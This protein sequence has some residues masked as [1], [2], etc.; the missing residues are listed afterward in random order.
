MCG[1]RSIP[2]SHHRNATQQILHLCFKVRELEFWRDRVPTGT[3]LFGG[4]GE[5]VLE[6]Q[7]ALRLVPFPP[8]DAL[9]LGP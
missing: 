1:L 5:L 3:P 6:L 9:S 8:G 4:R 7:T 2:L